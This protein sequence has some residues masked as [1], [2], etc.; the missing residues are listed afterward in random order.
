MGQWY[1]TAEAWIAEHGF[2]AYNEQCGQELDDRLFSDAHKDAFGFRPRE[3]W[4]YPH[5]DHIAAATEVVYG[6]ISQQIEMD[7]RL[8]LTSQY[9]LEKT[10]ASLMA[11]QNCSYRDALLQVAEHEKC[12]HPGGTGPR[13]GWIDEGQLCYELG[14]NYGL[15]DMLR[16]V[17]KGELV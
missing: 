12:Y 13:G 16:H 7:R 5:P 1:P 4:N 15:E 10:L 14:L 6:I 11:R 17:V 8:E 3:A 9:K 2:A